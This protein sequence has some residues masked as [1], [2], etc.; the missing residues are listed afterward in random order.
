MRERS[1]DKAPVVPRTPIR[2]RVVEGTQVTQ[3]QT[4]S[5]AFHVGREDSCG[6]QVVHGNVSRTH[7][8]VYPENGRWWVEDVGSSNGTFHHGEKVAQAPVEAEMHLALGLNGPV[9]VMTVDTLHE[10]REPRDLP[11]GDAHMAAAPHS[12]AVS[13]TAQDESEAA[14]PNPSLTYFIQH[15]AG[16]E[17]PAGERTVF[18]REAFRQ[19][20]QKQRRKY[21][22]FI[23]VA[24]LLAISAAGFGGYKAV[25]H[26]KQQVRIAEQQAQIEV[27]QAEIAALRVQARNIFYE[28]KAAEINA[29][30]SPDLQSVER[31]R[32]RRFQLSYAQYVDS[33]GI[34]KDLTEEHRL[35]YRMARLFGECDA[36]VPAAFVA[37][38]EEYIGRWQRSSRLR[39]GIQRASTEGFTGP[40]VETLMAQGLPPQYF[41]VALQESNFDVNAVGDS[42]R[43]S[44]AK[45]MWQFIPSTA[46]DYGLRVGPLAWS[47]EPDPYD[48]RHDFEKSTEAAARYIRRLYETDAQ[49]SGLL[50]MASYNWG[51]GNVISYIRQLPE[52]PS[53]RNFWK[54]VEQYG[55]RIPRETY[56]YVF[57]IFSAAVIGENPRL[58]GFDFDPPLRDAMMRAT[59]PASATSSPKTTS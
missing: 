38:V 22:G 18:I 16:D 6:L 45:G 59:Q 53:E 43:Y 57:S 28:M 39:F 31:Q 9:L 8:Y 12:E 47:K 51:E 10:D 3:E 21:T 37:R 15:Y 5:E 32:V 23:V 56:D 49:A 41:Y 35:I 20:H 55:D 42:T 13:G 44:F 25:E 26:R 7:L 40:I 11:A 58:F 1:T 27:Q 24:A 4:F 54:L 46:N 19:V 14:A 34:Y 48:D 36:D 29:A 2:V 30:A 17:G 33:L 50:V 52:K